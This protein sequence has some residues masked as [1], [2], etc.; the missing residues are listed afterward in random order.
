[1]SSLKI[2]IAMSLL[3]LCLTG[4]TN[5]SEIPVTIP[6]DR[7]LNGGSAVFRQKVNASCCVGTT[8]NVD[9]DPADMVD[10]SDIVAI[11]DY[12]VSSLP[13]SLCAAE[14]DVTRDGTIDIS[15]V[16]AL[17]D[18]LVIELPLPL[19]PGGSLMDPALRMAAIDLVTAKAK[20]LDWSNLSASNDQLAAYM[21]TLPEVD[22]AAVNSEADNVWALFTDGVLFMFVNNR[23]P[24]TGLSG[25]STWVSDSSLSDQSIVPIKRAQERRPT[26]AG[27]NAAGAELPLSV[28]ARLI[29]TLG[30]HFAPATSTVRNMLTA[31]GY[32]TA[33]STSGTVNGLKSVGGD[34]VLYFDA[35]GGAG[36]FN[37]AAT[38]SAFGLWTSSVATAANLPSYSA[39]FTARRICIMA[40]VVGVD[41]T[42]AEVIEAHY[43]ITS[44]FVTYYWGA[45][46]PNAMVFIDACSGASPFAAPFRNAIFAKNAS[47][48]FGWT[49]P[50]LSDAAALV[51]KFMFDRFIGA[52]TAAPKE[53]PP[54]RPFT[55]P[56]VY[57]DLVK[58]GLHIHPTPGGA[59]TTF[60]H[61]GGGGSF[62]LLAPSISFMSLE[63]PNDLLVINGIFG[64]DPGVDGRVRVDGGDLTIA[65]WT[66]TQIKCHIERS[67][68]GS[69]GPVTV[70]VRGDYGGLTPLTFRKSNVVNLTSW[71]IPFHYEHTE[72]PQ[73]IVVDMDLH[74]RADVHSHREVP[75]EAPIEA[76]AVLFYHA[77][78]S[79]GSFTVG[80]TGNLQCYTQTWS[81]ADT[82]PVTEN[83]TGV[84]VFYG[85]GSIDAKAKNITILLGALF[86]EGA[87]VHTCGSDPCPPGCA[88][89][90]LGW[91][92]DLSLYESFIPSPYFTMY[93]NSNFDL[94]QGERLPN[95]SYP[96][97][98]LGLFQ[99]T[100]SVKL[101]WP[102]VVAEFPPDAEAAQL[103]GQPTEKP[104]SSTTSTR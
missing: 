65:S 55:Y 14:N 33:T 43:G 46:G 27:A 94:L 12:L 37:A 53:T 1:M 41:G 4:I 42:G 89:G 71:R 45:F 36:Y 91:S 82:L 39:D 24:A 48:I 98:P 21:N 86:T 69:A 10:I 31:N 83:T 80:G 9:G 57:G 102:A 100:P 56:D 13:M 61:F 49:R 30:S 70:E 28:Q 22:T 3:A 20:T 16:Q 15:D 60:T 103:Q 77:L 85:R 23:G 47:A 63:E 72:G 97:L 35:H 18:Y 25:A 84:N 68:V 99:G 92:F 8:G 62:G 50:V 73:T 7:N 74:I 40:G 5:S 87:N 6:S 54:Q 59:T 88:D 52:N 78:D 32:F 17:V 58:R 34:G 64:T 79:E 44:R 90:L 66:P 19:C 76:D 29:E 104:Q 2:A 38:D 95:G 51:A 81:G 93:L 96:V 26:P 101:S 11:V 75:H 67:G